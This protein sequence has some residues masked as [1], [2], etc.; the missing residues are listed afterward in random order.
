MG[1]VLADLD[2]LVRIVAKEAR[3]FLVAPKRNHLQ[4]EHLANAHQVFLV[5]VLGVVLLEVDF[6]EAENNL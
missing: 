2:M 5:V 1:V 3:H 4:Q 6:L